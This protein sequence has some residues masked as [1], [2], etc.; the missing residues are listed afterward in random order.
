[1][2]LQLGCFSCHFAKIHQNQRGW[3]RW[4]LSTHCV[5]VE[6]K[7]YETKCEWMVHSKNNAKQVFVFSF[8]RF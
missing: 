3:V 1:M 8:V 5:T 2:F 6:M 7:P 4:V